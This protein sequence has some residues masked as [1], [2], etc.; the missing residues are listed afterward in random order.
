M[1]TINEKPKSMNNFKENVAAGIQMTFE[2]GNTI[3]IQFGYGNYCDNR[4][5]SQM[6]CKNA[7]IA[8]WD[9][10]GIWHNFGNDTVKGYC[11]TDEIADFIYFAKTYKIKQ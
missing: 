4:S 9:K 7:E 6:H 1:I 10:D 11:N 5:E 8:I 3:S 2:N